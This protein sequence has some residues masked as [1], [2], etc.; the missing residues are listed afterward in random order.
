MK[1]E[2]T[3]DQIN[4]IFILRIIIAV[5]GMITTI[6]FY[7]YKYVK[8]HISDI[9]S[10]IMA[11]FIFLLGLVLIVLCFEFKKIWLV[12]IGILL[13]IGS[14][15]GIT[16]SITIKI[17]EIDGVSKSVILILLLLFSG[18]IIYAIIIKKKKCLMLEKKRK[19]EALFFEIDRLVCLCKK[20]NNLWDLAKHY[21][22]ASQ[23]IN[24]CESL[25]SEHKDVQI[26]NYYT[27]KL[28]NKKQEYIYNS[29]IR[30]YIYIINCVGTKQLQLSNSIYNYSQNLRKSIK[31]YFDRFD[32]N[33]T[34]VAAVLLE[35]LDR[36]ITFTQKYARAYETDSRYNIDEMK[37]QDFERYCA[38]LLIAYGF[39]NVEVTRGS[40]DQ[41]V[42]IIAKYDGVKV[43]IQCKRYSHKL[44][45][46]PIQ[47]VVAG[48]NYYNCSR[49]MVITN[50]F[51]TDSAIDL[52]KANNVLLWNRNDLMQLIYYTDNQWND[53][54]EAVKI[55]FEEKEDT[56]ETLESDGGIVHS[57]TETK[58]WRCKKCGF[59]VIDAYKY[60]PFCKYVGTKHLEEK[61]N[62]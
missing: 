24:Y 10:L 9:E 52:A 41:G 46:G 5:I 38:N 44:G 4:K 8:I 15:S 43:A 61:N 60:C 7:L 3:L 36:I 27:N 37:G 23:I 1:R 25:S 18:Y 11:P 16:D 53:L 19:K 54:L 48:K 47:E 55:E 30:N 28:N 20:D 51:F 17:S 32:E 39:C 29:M 49:A 58:K 42:D 26:L 12:I 21:N 6:S 57:N 35:K 50:N 62:S 45:N 59:E 34:K 13:M 31:E 40:G 22:E 14:T 56:N 2:N 33:N